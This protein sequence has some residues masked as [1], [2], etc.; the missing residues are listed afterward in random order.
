MA[1]YSAWDWN[2][3]AF[4]VFRDAKPSSIGD[5]PS[6]PRPRTVSILGAVPDKDVKMLP[7][8]ARS[9]GTSRVAIG[10]IVRDVRL[11]T[12]KDAAAAK[13]GGGDGIGALGDAATWVP[14]APLLAITAVF[15]AMAIFRSARKRPR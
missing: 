14:Y 11:N 8:G 12:A 6:P 7:S 9:I 4:R 10:E 15:A 5:D 13:S 1:D 3:N 2:I